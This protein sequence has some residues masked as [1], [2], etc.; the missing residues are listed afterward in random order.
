MRR[1]TMLTISV[2]ALIGSAQAQR[3]ISP[4]RPYAPVEVMFPAL[5]GDAA[6]DTFRGE[7]VKAAQ[8]RVYVE[9]ARLVSAQGFFWGRDFANRFDPRRAGV[10]NLAAALQL[11]RDGGAGWLAL[12][13]LAGEARAALLES[14]PGVICAPAPQRYD[15]IALD[16]LVETTRTE[17][18]DWQVTRVPDVAVRSA[19]R[20]EAA[21]LD[22]LG[23]QFVRVLPGAA[24]A[25][26]GWTEVVAPTGATGFVAP[27]T[28]RR[29]EESRLCYRRNL[30]GHWQITGYIG[31]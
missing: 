19:P 4:A 2:L 21:T 12:E 30:T 1:L 18:G 20:T 6:W 22:V 28:L 8:G 5:Q 31:H 15:V 16:Q 3:V 17:P 23:L 24:S 10:D 11:E 26:S 29:V 9:L 25:N 13:R 7:V 27:G 14:R